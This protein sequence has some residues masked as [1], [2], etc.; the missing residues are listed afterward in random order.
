MIIKFFDEFDGVWIDITGSTGS[1]LEYDGSGWTSTPEYREIIG[2]ISQSGVTDPVLNEY[3]NAGYTL[4]ATYIDVGE[5]NIE[6]NDTIFDFNF[7]VNFANHS[8]IN[9]DQVTIQ[10]YVEDSSNLRIYTY[11]SGSLSDDILLDTPFEIRIYG[12]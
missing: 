6:I 2:T 3:K 8:A 7:W 1:S 11:K 10:T 4:T 12:N 9:N 5:Y